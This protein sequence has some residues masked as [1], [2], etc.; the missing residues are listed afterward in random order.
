MELRFI[1]SWTSNG[2]RRSRVAGPSI[3]LPAR[4]V[5]S[6]YDGLVE[7][8]APATLLARGAANSAADRSQRIR[9]ARDQIRKFVA[10]VR[11]GP[12]VAT[13]VGMNGARGLAVDLRFP[14]L[15]V[16]EFD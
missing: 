16:G 12:D 10:A 3:W 9:P 14:V 7:F 4:K 1:E 11:Y 5:N 6:E 13:G 8:A 2:K 15:T